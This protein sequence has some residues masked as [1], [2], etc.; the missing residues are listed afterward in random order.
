MSLSGS[1]EAGEAC[2]SGEAGLEA[3][4]C[5]DSP[6]LWPALHLRAHFPLYL[7][8]TGEGFE[9]LHLRDSLCR[10]ETLSQDD[11]IG[12]GETES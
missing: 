4:H 11:M 7:T 9:P 12:T 6:A 5:G 1:C 2:V 10:D 8:S 3:L